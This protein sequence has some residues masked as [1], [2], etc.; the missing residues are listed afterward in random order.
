MIVILTY[1]DFI[2]E[3]IDRI[4]NGKKDINSPYKNVGIRRWKKSVSG[5][6]FPTQKGISLKFPEWTELLRVFDEIFLTHQEIYTATSC[7]LDK[8]IA[9]H[10]KSK[11]EECISMEMPPLGMVDIIIPI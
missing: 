5:K 3:P 9:G 4:N 6:I 8:E 10:D 11:C 2:K 1:V 7:L